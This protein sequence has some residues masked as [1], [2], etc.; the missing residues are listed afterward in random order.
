MTLHALGAVDRR[1]VLPERE[2]RRGLGGGGRRQQCH[3]QAGDHL[4]QVT[5]S[6]N[7]I[8]PLDERGYFMFKASF[9]SLAAH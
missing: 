4:R 8:T 2:S 6:V 1:D 7:E 3:R 9:V 5:T